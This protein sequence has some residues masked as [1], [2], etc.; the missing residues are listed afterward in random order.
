MLVYSVQIY[1]VC[2]DIEITVEYTASNI[3]TT[4][5]I[6][7]GCSTA[8]QSRVPGRLGNKRT[9]VSPHAMPERGKISQSVLRMRDVTQKRTLTPYSHKNK[10]TLHITAYIYIARNRTASA[11]T[12]ALRYPIRLQ[13]HPG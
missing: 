13:K 10:Y 11:N 8:V 4:V 5:F 6:L 7:Y 12:L 2:V 3:E 9:T 1:V